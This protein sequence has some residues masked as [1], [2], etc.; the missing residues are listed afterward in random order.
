MRFRLCVYILAVGVLG[1]PSNSGRGEG[2]YTLPTPKPLPTQE[3]PCYCTEHVR[4]N[5]STSSDIN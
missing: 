3:F 2:D 5:F 1:S 4:H